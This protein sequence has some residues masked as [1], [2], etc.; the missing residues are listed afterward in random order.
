MCV[1]MCVHGLTAL[2]YKPD[3]RNTSSVGVNVKFGSGKDFS[4][5]YFDYHSKH[6]LSNN[7]VLTYDTMILSDMNLLSL[8]SKREIQ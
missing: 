2:I 5:A 4:L 7:T 1:Y 8:K 3:N 6:I